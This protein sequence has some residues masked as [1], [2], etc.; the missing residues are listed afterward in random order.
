MKKLILIFLVLA[1]TCTYAQE[2]A[3]LYRLQIDD[4]ELLISKIQIDSTISVLKKRMLNA[5]Y[6]NSTIAYNNSKKEFI[7][8]SGSVIE[9]EFISNWLV[10]PCE[11]SFYET[12]TAIELLSVLFGYPNHD[13]DLD[14]KKAF[15]TLLNTSDSIINERRIPNVGLIKS[16]DT[17]EFNLLSKN[18]KPHLPEDCLLAYQWNQTLLGNPALAIFALRN[19]V[20]KL[21]INEILDHIKMAFGDR[22]EPLLSIRFN[23]IGAKK[24]HAMTLKNVNK[25]IGIV[26]DGT[27]Y[28]APFVYSPIE[29]GNVQIS[30]AFTADEA[31]LLVNMLAG[32]YLPIRLIL[33]KQISD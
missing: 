31:K 20:S 33:V 30:G 24:F 5:G 16:S 10:K 18:L 11:V 14:K 29:G 15:Y 3:N 9:D 21:A 6:K 25:S 2:K 27:V 22:G 4:K 12:Y 7:V 23:K 8:E 26:I 28:S 13:I 19:N 17:I 1:T 32:G